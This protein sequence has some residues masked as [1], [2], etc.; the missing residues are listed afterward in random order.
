[1]IAKNRKNI[2]DDKCFLMSIDVSDALKL[3]LEISTNQR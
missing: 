3:L 2:Q 1:M